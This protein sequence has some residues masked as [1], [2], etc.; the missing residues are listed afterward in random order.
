M[1]DASVVELLILI[2]V[3]VLI[4]MGSNLLDREFEKGVKYQINH[5]LPKIAVLN[6]R[7]AELEAVNDE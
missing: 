1:V 5:S 7:I 2:G 3:C 4:Y 6:A